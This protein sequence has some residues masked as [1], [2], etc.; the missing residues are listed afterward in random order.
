M[1]C[2]AGRFF[3]VWATRESLC[4]ERLCLFPFLMEET[5]V[6][7]SSVG[8][9]SSYLQ[10]IA[11]WAFFKLVLFPYIQNIK[12]WSSLGHWVWWG[13]AEVLVVESSIQV[14]ALSPRSW[15]NLRKPLGTPVVGDGQGGL[16]FCDSWGCKEVDTNEWLNWTRYSVSVYL[17]CLF[18]KVFIKCEIRFYKK[19]DINMKNTYTDW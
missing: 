9:P 19:Q 7:R 3:I 17:W 16:A 18:H 6:Q 14:L 5:G 15:E 11:M 10:G 2:H 13:R 4:R 1:G 8:C 12:T